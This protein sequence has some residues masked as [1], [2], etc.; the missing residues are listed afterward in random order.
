MGLMGGGEQAQ[1]SLTPATFAGTA[2]ISADE[3]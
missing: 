2:H 1:I 3:G